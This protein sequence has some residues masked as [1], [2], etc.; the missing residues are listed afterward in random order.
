MSWDSLF[1]SALGKSGAGKHRLVKL[2]HNTSCSGIH[3]EYRMCGYKTTAQ[4]LLLVTL[5]V[6]THTFKNLKDTSLGKY[7]S[8]LSRD[9]PCEQ[10]TKLTFIIKKKSSKTHAN[11]S[12]LE[13]THW[14]PFFLTALCLY[15][16][17]VG[18]VRSTA[19]SKTPLTRHCP[20]F[21]FNNRS[22]LVLQS[23]VSNNASFSTFFLK[24]WKIYQILILV[25]KDCLKRSSTIFSFSSI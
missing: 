23:F 7:F 21:K 1:R 6:D 3:C 11:D 25:W 8:F 10:T 15:T 22:E 5:R 9:F 12:Y 20:H 16:A 2:Y 18:A 4:V 14:K 13:D 19:R 17:S 24:Y